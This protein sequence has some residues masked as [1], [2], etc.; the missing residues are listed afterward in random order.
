VLSLEHSV[1]HGKM[2][3]I[4]INDGVISIL[5]AVKND[6][7]LRMTQLTIRRKFN[8]FSDNNSLAGVDKSVDKVG[9]Y[10]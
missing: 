8:T 7:V 10:L 2:R 9:G 6:T 4:P 5:H 1:K 3:R